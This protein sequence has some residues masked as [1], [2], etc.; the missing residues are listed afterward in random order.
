MLTFLVGGARS[1]KS[2]LAVQMGERAGGPV[3]FLATAEPFDADLQARV[4]RHRTERPA[5][6]MTVEEPV[7]LA[8]A[9]RAVP[10]SSFL[11]VDCLTVWVANLGVRGVL[12]P[13][14]TEMAADAVAEL[15]A[16]RG[17]GAAPSVVV[18]NEVGLGI[19][20]ADATNRT[21]RDTLG[22][23]NQMVAAVADTTLFMAAGRAVRLDDPWTLLP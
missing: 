15:T 12:A 7:E 3:T 17:R 14:I 8:G 20:P 22:R 2:T 9:V 16:R 4:A 5:G 6:W 11:I 1:G 23:V 21:Y 18:S 19:V 10:D 13:R